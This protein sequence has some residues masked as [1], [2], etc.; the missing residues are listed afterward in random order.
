M[1]NLFRM[2]VG[3]LVGGSFLLLTP[4]AGNCGPADGLY[5]KAECGRKRNEGHKVARVFW[6]RNSRQ[7]S[8]T[9]SGSAVW[10]YR[11]LRHM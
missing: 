7:Q 11:R 2:V 1:K 9:G 6:A 10:A 4:L 5:F 3:L 8:P